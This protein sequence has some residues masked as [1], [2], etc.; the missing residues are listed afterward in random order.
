MKN[1]CILQ[2]SLAI[3]PFQTAQTQWDVAEGP[4]KRLPAKANQLKH[5]ELQVWPS[6]Q[7][8]DARM[9]RALRLPMPEERENSLTLRGGS[10]VQ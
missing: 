1:H 8:C 4:V 3:C 7:F 6:V 9:A 2:E 10:H 5:N